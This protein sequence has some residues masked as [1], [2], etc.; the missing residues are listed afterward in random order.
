MR[1]GTLELEGKSR[2]EVLR[3]LLSRLLTSGFVQGVLV[4]KPLADGAAVVH[5][6]VVDPS[7]RQGV[8]PASYQQASPPR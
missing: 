5:S 6:L 8:L 3:G 4:P 1:N 7:Q 2:N